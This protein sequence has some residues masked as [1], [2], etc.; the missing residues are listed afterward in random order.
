MPDSISQLPT[1]MDRNISHL[2]IDQHQLHWDISDYCCIQASE[3]QALLANRI[4]NGETGP[5]EE[6]RKIEIEKPESLIATTS[7][8]LEE[9]LP[10]LPDTSINSPEPDSVS[11]HNAELVVS[12]SAS[13][14]ESSKVEE[15]AFVASD[16]GN[17][18]DVINDF[19]EAIK[20]NSDV[21]EGRGH[22][23]ELQQIQAVQSH[24][25]AG[26]VDETNLRTISY[27]TIYFLLVLIISSPCHSSMQVFYS[28][29]PS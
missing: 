24:L 11:G 7:V 3:R 6:L 26:I 12:A 29:T 28:L 5:A 22:Y 10:S 23:N 15:L 14:P 17:L 25:S 13:T 4:M 8:N 19:D 9:T 27:V 18:N 21:N 1:P 16:E 2:Q 20:L